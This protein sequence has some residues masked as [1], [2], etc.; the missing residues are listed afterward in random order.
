MAQISKFQIGSKIW[1]ADTQT[2]AG[3]IV[4]DGNSGNFTISPNGNVGVGTTS[5][6]LASGTGLVI[7]NASDTTRLELRNS[8]TGNL[9]TDGMGLLG[10]SNNFVIFNRESGFLRFDVN[11]SERL[12]IE[13]SGLVG[14]NETSPSSQLQVK[15]GATGRI[16]L[17]VDTLASHTVNIAEYKANGSNVLIVAANGLLRTDAGIS[18]NTT[19][20]N[21]YVNTSQ[22]GTIISR[23]IADGNPSLTVVAQHASSGDITRFQSNISGTTATRSYIDKNGVFYKT[24][25]KLTLTNPTFT[26]TG[27]GTANFEYTLTE[28]QI[29]ANDVI[30]ITKDATANGQLYRLIIPNN[31]KQIRIWFTVNSS[32]SS[33]IAEVSLSK[34]LGES[35]EY[36]FDRQEA[37]GVSLLKADTSNYINYN[38]SNDPISFLYRNVNGTQK[39][40]SVSFVNEI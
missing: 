20:N 7:F 28:A 38:V 19:A 15:S 13:S 23:N 8:V 9:S 22:L 10:S 40:L 21:S 39:S 36:I 34:V 31:S 29:N 12:K 37:N 35:V 32:G 14:I 33:T 5:P 16:P 17:I 1:N 25:T 18:N 4:H 30:E 24:E 6:N 3:T 2:D 26:E 11:G 27:V